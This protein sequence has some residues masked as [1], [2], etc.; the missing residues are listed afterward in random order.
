LTSIGERAFE[1]FVP[2]VLDL[3]DRTIYSV[4]SADEV[5]MFVD[6]LERVAAQAQ[7][8]LNQSPTPG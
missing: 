8:L 4:L 7:N 3:L 5:K 2:Q 1:E 6:L